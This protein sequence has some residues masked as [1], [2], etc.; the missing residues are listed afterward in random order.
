MKNEILDKSPILIGE[1]EFVEPVSEKA[2]KGSSDLNIKKIGKCKVEVYSGEGA[3][4]H[5]HMSNADKSFSSCVCIY[6]PNYFSHGGKYSGTLNATQREELFTWLKEANKDNPNKTN[7]EVIVETW[8]LSNPN[9]KF[10]ADNKVSTIP[11]YKNMTQYL[12]E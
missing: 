2:I 12:S 3:I 9:C 8:E 10:P 1:I 5:F 7:W 6:S 4:P 11:Y